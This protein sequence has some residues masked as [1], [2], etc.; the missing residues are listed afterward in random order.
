MSDHTQQ[1]SWFSRNW[2]WFV[3]VSG[4][5]VV[6]LL[7][8]LGIGGLFF[9]V[10]KLFTGSEPYQYAL[11]Q[12]KSNPNVL[13][14]LGEP[15]ETDG[16]MS[17]NISIKNDDGNADFSIPIKGANGEARIIVVATKDYGSW[18]YEE[19][20]VQI[21]NTNEKINLL[22]KSLEGI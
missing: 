15:I 22:D 14:S 5:L 11:E 9:G 16:I 21:K 1:K 17:G 13:L 20:Y 4:C 10:S 12:A 8:V 7:F 2:L 19:L 18:V 6:I 3:P